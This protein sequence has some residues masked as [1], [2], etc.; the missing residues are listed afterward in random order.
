[1][2]E[3]ECYVHWVFQIVDI[4]QSQEAWPITLQYADTVEDLE[5]TQEEEEE[6]QQQEVTPWQEAIPEHHQLTIKRLAHYL[7]HADHMI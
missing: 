2:F 5:V 1:M 6:A 3:H 7:K 4:T